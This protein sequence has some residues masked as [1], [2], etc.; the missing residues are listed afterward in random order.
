MLIL[1][2][3]CLE[4]ARQRVQGPKSRLET[5]YSAHF[6]SSKLRLCTLDASL[7]SATIRAVEFRRVTRGI[8]NLICPS[9]LWQTLQ[10]SRRHHV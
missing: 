9:M 2:F 8:K 10:T 4:L 6:F 3:G 1:A 7:R 5:R